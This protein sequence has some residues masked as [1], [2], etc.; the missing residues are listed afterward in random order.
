MSK[1]CARCGAD[2]SP[3]TGTMEANQVKISKL[4]AWDVD[5]PSPICESCFGQL[6]DQTS[7]QFGLEDFYF[8]EA[9][10]KDFRDK[11]FKAIDAVEVFTFNP[12]EFGSYRNLGLVTGFVVL[13]TGPLTSIATTITDVLGQ[14]SQIY[15]EKLNQAEVSCLSKLKNNAHKKGATAVIGLQ[16]TFQE[17]TAINGMLL[18]AMVGTAVNLYSQQTQPNQNLL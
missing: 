8:E 18:V 13:G 10:P 9:P 6:I 16:V 17:L 7:R 4:R 11:V 3:F 15:N 12:Y 5:V 2:L 1:I 14:D